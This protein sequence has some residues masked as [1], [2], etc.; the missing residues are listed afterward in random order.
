[1]PSRVVLID[2]FVTG[3]MPALE[4]LQLDAGPVPLDVLWGYYFGTGSFEPVVRIVSVLKW[5][6][7]A[8]DVEHLTIGSMAKWT[9]ATNASRDVEL[10]RL[11]KSA[12]TVGSI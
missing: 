4:G 1:M 6:K 5:A 3:R 10:L 7:D 9:L 12:M 11:L 2:R 8:D